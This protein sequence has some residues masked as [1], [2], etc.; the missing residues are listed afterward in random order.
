VSAYDWFG[1]LLCQP[2]GL[3]LAGIAAAAI[4]MSRTLWIAAAIQ[5]LAIVAMLATP[6]VRRLRA[7]ET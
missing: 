2:I 1:S 3:A 7:V 5:I 6:S 4:G